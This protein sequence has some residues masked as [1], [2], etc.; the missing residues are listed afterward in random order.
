MIVLEGLGEFLE[1]FGGSR[2]CQEGSMSTK[3]CTCQGVFE[4]PKR[5]R[6]PQGWLQKGSRNSPGD[7]PRSLAC[8]SNDFV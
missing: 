4:L 2:S 6:V 3:R 1:V 5:P 7:A 8:V